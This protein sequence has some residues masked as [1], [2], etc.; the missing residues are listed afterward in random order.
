MKPH[1]NVFIRFI[2]AVLFSVLCIGGNTVLAAKEA[3]ISEPSS[4]VLTIKGEPYTRVVII[5]GST[6]AADN[7]TVVQATFERAY[8]GGTTPQAI[9][10]AL[11]KQSPSTISFT[12]KK[13]A[14]FNATQQANGDFSGTFINH[15]G[16]QKEATLRQVS[17]EELRAEITAQDALRNENLIEQPGAN[18]PKECAAFSGKWSGRMALGTFGSKWLWVTK[19]IQGC[20]IRFALLSN[21]HPPKK[22]LDGVIQDGKFSYNCNKGA[23]NDICNFTLHGDEIWFDYIVPGDGSAGNRAVLE[24]ID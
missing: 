14:Q 16:E 10:I 5:S 20:K 18:V 2:A 21:P 15:K 3:A 8:T 11:S 12:T 6:V 24:K 19:V 17:P 23:P 22:L 1:S 9:S 7:T 13:D 4:W